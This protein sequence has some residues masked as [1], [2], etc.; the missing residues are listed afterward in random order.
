MASCFIINHVQGSGVTAK[1][2]ANATDAV[3]WIRGQT[4]SLRLDLVEALKIYP[5]IKI[6]ESTDQKLLLKL[7]QFEQNL[8]ILLEFRDDTAYMSGLGF[9]PMTALCLG[10]RLPKDVNVIK[11]Y[12]LAEFRK[13][14][15]LELISRTVT[16]I[17]TRI[18]T[19]SFLIKQR[20]RA[21]SLDVCERT[22]ILS[23]GE[24]MVK[25]FDHGTLTENLQAANS[26]MNEA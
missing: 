14:D 20:A 9:A 18:D 11:E 6:E 7:E 2:F 5:N 26:L 13:F 16:G 1:A 24:G 4:N 21:W 15:L 22:V 25:T 3:A 23:D 8:F 12:I 19:G 17:P 10:C